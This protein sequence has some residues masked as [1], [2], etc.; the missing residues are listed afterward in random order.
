L[1]DSGASSQLEDNTDRHAFDPWNRS[2]HEKGML[3]HPNTS[4]KLLQEYEVTQRFLESPSEE[5]FAAV[6]KTF[7][8]GEDLAQDVMFIVC[9]KADQLRDRALFRAWLFKVARSALC[10]HYGRKW[11]EVE[12]VEL[13]RV[14]DLLVA[15]A[16]TVAGTPAFEFL[17]WIS[18]LK[19][20]EQEMLTLRFIEQWEYH[21]IA[22]AKAIP[23]GTVQWRVFNAKKKLVPLLRRCE[24]SGLGIG[25][26]RG[27]TDLPRYQ[28]PGV[29]PADA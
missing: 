20:Q 18:F 28:N 5:T 23:I 7:T 15:S 16:K 10:R 24:A 1:S 29:I 11:R 6:F 27:G 4:E 26:R 9:R 12:M 19:P 25:R 21:E 14:V 17:H 22:A 8:P 2:C 13:D 3:D